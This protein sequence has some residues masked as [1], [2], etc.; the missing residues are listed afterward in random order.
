VTNAALVAYTIIHMVARILTGEVG[1]VPQAAIPVAHV[2][3]NRLP[4]WGYDGWHAIADEPADWATKAAEKAYWMWVRGETGG[5]LF[6][7]SDDDC[8]AL[9]VTWGTR[10]GNERWGITVTR[11]W[12]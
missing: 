3:Y 12:P 8:E 10:Y 2:A 5:N 1:V 7:L 4:V 11:R 6:A 9:G